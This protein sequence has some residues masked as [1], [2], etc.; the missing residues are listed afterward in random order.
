MTD[1]VGWMKSNNK[2]W[3][4]LC[5]FVLL[6]WAGVLLSSLG[7]KADTIAYDFTGTLAS[8]AGTAKGTFTLDLTPVGAFSLANSSTA[9]VLQYTPAFSPT[10]QTS[11]SCYSLTRPTRPT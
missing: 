3:A 9:T 1:L 10:I 5:S 8:N 4:S 11:S 2:S 6:V 7:A